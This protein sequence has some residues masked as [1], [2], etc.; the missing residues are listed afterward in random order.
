MQH[1]STFV[2]ACGQKLNTNNQN[3]FQNNSTRQIQQKTHTQACQRTFAYDC[4][5]WRTGT[6]QVL[7]S[8]KHV[9]ALMSNM[10]AH[11]CMRMYSLCVSGSGLSLHFSS[12][13]TPFDFKKTLCKC[14]ILR[15]ANVMLSTNLVQQIDL[16]QSHGKRYIE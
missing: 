5:N 7:F 8:Y 1:G 2:R 3:L 9:H 10:C 16:F 6:A 15:W 12:C 13:A 11:V 14:A 4:L